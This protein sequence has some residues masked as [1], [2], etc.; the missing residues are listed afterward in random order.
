M[1]RRRSHAASVGQPN[2]LAVSYLFNPI[3]LVLVLLFADAK[4]GMV[5]V[6]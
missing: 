5:Q 3:V 1:R 4:R 6:S 2:G